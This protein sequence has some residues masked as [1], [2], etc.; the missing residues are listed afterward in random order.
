MK[1]SRLGRLTHGV[2]L[3]IYARRLLSDTMIPL[4]GNTFYLFLNSNS[5]FVVD[6]KKHLIWTWAISTRWASPPVL[7][8]LLPREGYRQ[9]CCDSKTCSQCSKRAECF[10]RS[11]R[12]RLME[13]H[14][15]T[16]KTNAQT[17]LGISKR[18]TLYANATGQY[19][20]AKPCSVCVYHPWDRF[21]APW[22]REKAG[23]RKR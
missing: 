3:T 15:Q 17:E 10:G 20:N 8:K 6:K 7:E 16:L 22:R 12:R 2:H 21:S 4:S 14:K 19:A 18:N 13:R 23:I 11:M 9:Y 1:Y 5:G